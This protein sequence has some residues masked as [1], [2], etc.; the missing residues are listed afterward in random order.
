[1]ITM[2]CTHLLIQFLLRTPLP[3]KVFASL[4]VYATKFNYFT[5]AFIHTQFIINYNRVS[6]YTVPKN[7]S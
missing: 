1:M 4:H 6:S 3:R 2:G 7:R 5:L